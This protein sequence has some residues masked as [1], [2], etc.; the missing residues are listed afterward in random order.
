MD[1]DG[2][3]IKVS[4]WLKEGSRG[5]FM[6]CKVEYKDAPR[7]APVEAP[8]APASDSKPAGGFGDMDDDIPF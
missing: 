3:P 7:N 4:A 2:N 1:P 5:K 6:S 8:S